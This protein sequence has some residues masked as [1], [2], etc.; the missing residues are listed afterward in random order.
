MDKIDKQINKLTAS[1]KKQ[2]KEVF[3]K[4]RQNE[5]EYLDVKK[6][7]GEDDIYRVRKG[8]IRII[9][10]RKG[11]DIYILAVGLRDEDTYKNL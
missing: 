2:V 6:L 10:Q 8:D 9:F 11:D 3:L 5:L 1:R 7:K 4:L